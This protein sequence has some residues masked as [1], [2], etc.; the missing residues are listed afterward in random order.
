MSLIKINTDDITSGPIVR[1]IVSLAIPV[2]LGMFMEFALT[3]TDFY[4]VGKLGPTAQDAITTSMVVIWTI[5]A[6]IT[7]LS[8]GV[9][10]LVSRYVG[11]K[12][13]DLT[14]F[15][16]NQGMKLALIL[17]LLFS[18]T[19]FILAPSIIRF[20]GPGEATLARAIPYLRIFMVS[21]TFYA[22]TDTAYAVFRAS[23][24]TVTPT[25]IGVL[26]VLVNMGLDP[27]FIFGLGPFPELGVAG[28]S[29][30]SAISIFISMLIVYYL[31]FSGKLGYRV[32]SLFRFKPNIAGMAK[33]IKIGLPIS[34]Q[35][36][37]FI[38]VY[39]FLI[40]IV[41]EFGADAGAAMGIGNR[42]E[43]LSYLTCY[44][45]SLAASTMVGQNL[46]AKKPDRAAK[47][48]WGAA[49]LA[50]GF[51]FVIAFFFVVFNDFIAGI[52]TQNA[53]V[54]KIAADYLFILGLSQFTMAVEIVIEGSFS[55]AGN[56]IPP[57]AVL[58][59]GAIARIPLAYY[60]CFNLNWGVNGVWW[61]LTIT[62]T[63]KALILAFWFKLGRWKLKQV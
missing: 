40:K 58:L 21:C 5:Y 49:G 22:M 11:A 4:W 51:T 56:T 62:T 60:L 34:F 17:G 25:K 37:V 16:I 52:F 42:M 33:I 12:D 19:G 8:V 63:V 45:F 36:F 31:T 38:V 28:A 20:M 50:I 1:S 53:E 59:P 54:R 41:H 55:G 18:L 15:Y 61:T 7:L 13:F 48:A 14:R 27:L 3:V 2:V 26:M 29:V 35:Q 44:G 30:A 57:M 46:G 9:T 6:F 43:S 10:A 32:D 39:W 24:D 23:G 47:C